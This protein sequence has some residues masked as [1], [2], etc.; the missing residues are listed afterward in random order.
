MGGIPVPR[1]EPLSALRVLAQSFG[2]RWANV[3]ARDRMVVDD[4]EIVARHPAVADW[5]RQKVRNDDSLVLELRWRD[6]SILLTGDIGREVERTLAATIPPARLRVLKIP[7]HGS[8]TSSSSEFVRAL[9]PTVAV[10]SAGRGN[11]FGH[12]VPEV[13]ERYRAAGAEVFRTDR[14]GAVTVE[15]DGQAIAM[16]NILGQTTFTG[17]KRATKARR[18]EDTRE[19][20]S[21]SEYSTRLSDELED[22]IYRTIGCCITVH[23]ELGPGLLESIYMRAICFE[24][25]AEGI[26]FERER[27]IPVVYREQLPLQPTAGSRRG[28]SGRCRGEGS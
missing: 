15:T 12:P 14:D 28:Q 9:H 4:V 25:N 20:L 24:L 1:S 6:V 17:V 22:L 10:V 13:L 16:Q 27:L 7:H 8:L 5:E 21:C 2:S 3:Y 26:R 18:H 23:R 19:R 11:H